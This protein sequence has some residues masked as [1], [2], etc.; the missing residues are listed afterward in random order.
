VYIQDFAVCVYVALVVQMGSVEP[1]ET[2][3][4]A[5]P[6]LLVSGVSIDGAPVN[7]LRLWRF[8]NGDLMAGC[9]YII[10][11]LR[12]SYEQYWD[13]QQSKYVH[14][15]TRAKDVRM[16]YHGGRRMSAIMELA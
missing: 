9:I 15:H 16:S 13:E 8:E 5:Q 11:G 14:Q 6:Y 1:K 4:N 12:V 3:N 2:Q 10:R 7:Y